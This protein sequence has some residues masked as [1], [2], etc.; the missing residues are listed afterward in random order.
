MQSPQQELLL[1][2]C[3]ARASVTVLQSPPLALLQPHTS[4]SHQ[5]LRSSNPTTA[6]PQGTPNN[7]SRG[8]GAGSAL[9]A[10]LCGGSPGR[11]GLL[12]TP[13]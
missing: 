2:A 3:C 11:G 12:S 7:K 6:C 4:L 8:R 10:A 13:S 1:S 9:T 5:L